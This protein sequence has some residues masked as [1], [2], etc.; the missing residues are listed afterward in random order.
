MTLRF[1]PLTP[2]VGVEVMGV[3]LREQQPTAVMA[4]IGAAWN[5]AGVVLFRDQQLSPEAQL[6][7]SGY[8]GPIYRTR[9][10]NQSGSD[11]M[12]IGNV[13]VGGVPSA[14]PDGEMWFHQDGCYTE[15]PMRQTFLYALELPAHGGN[16]RF[17]STVDAYQRLPA[18]DRERLHSL[19]IRFSYNYAAV[20]RDAS[21]Q[22]TA[23]YEHPLV[24]AHPAT[25]KPLLFCNRLMAEEIVGL[26]SDEGQ[27]LIERLCTELECETFVYEHVWELGDFLM[28]D[29]LATAHART[30]FDPR[31]K[32][33]LRRSTTEG[34]KLHAY[35]EEVRADRG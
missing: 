23:S 10:G 7:F 31:E 14:L 1:R 26:P 22:P 27:A 25:G 6:A 11:F 8:F 17:A 21:L 13:E 9:K 34:V 19:R 32:R 2:S 35:R 12:H 18:A 20:T 5:E 30:D 28:W 15:C 4:E 24:I 3:D 33:L 16:T 29:N